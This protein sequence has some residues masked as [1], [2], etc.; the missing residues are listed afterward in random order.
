MRRCSGAIKINGVE[1]DDT[2]RG[3]VETA[4][5]EADVF[6]L[7]L[8]SETGACDL[9]LQVL[10]L[11]QSGPLDS[12]CRRILRLL[13]P[14]EVKVLL[15]H[16]HLLPH[17]LGPV[18]PLPDLDAVE[19]F[20]ASLKWGGSMYGWQ[21]FDNPDSD[22]HWPPEPSLT[23]R[24]APKPAPH[25]FY[26]FNECGRE[27]NGKAKGYLFQGIVTFKDLVILRADRTAIP[28]DEFISDGRRAWD[29]MYARDERMSV[30]AQR[31]A[32]RATP[33]WRSWAEVSGT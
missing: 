20:F 33:K 1:W 18:I 2:T 8:D 31:A 19:S 30:E 9:L 16:E 10:A 25:T 3:G 17:G 26:W 24:L 28:I 7:R 22:K 11:P 15:R 4:L 14:S 23:I 12:D 27:E 13:T 21:F 32:Q 29:A 5:N 6:G